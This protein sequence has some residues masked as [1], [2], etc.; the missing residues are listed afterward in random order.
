MLLKHDEKED[1]SVL[2]LARG[3]SLAKDLLRA[4]IETRYGFSPPQL[5][6]LQL[7]VKGRMRA[8]LGPVSRWLPFGATL[9][10]KLPLSFHYEYT[11]RLSG[12]PVRR[13]IQAY[14][15]MVLRH[16]EGG[17]PTVVTDSQVIQSVQQR[18]W[19][20]LSLLLIPLTE[21]HITLH[22]AGEHLIEATNSVTDD[23][24]LIVLND[25]Y[26]VQYVQTTA[27]NPQEEENQVFR[28]ELASEYVNI[29]GLQLPE[30]ITCSWDDEP[31]LE[32]EPVEAMV[33][34]PMGDHLFILDED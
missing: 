19:A 29:D 33:N 24:A 12:V 1:M 3:D 17:E 18:L 2:L 7:E 30:T 31:F 26:S 20:A 28:L 10:L 13:S 6:A 5:E 9:T 11:L 8:R 22:A 15:G 16:D 4:A 32:I 27:F 14:D 21:G 25:D 23:T 34:P